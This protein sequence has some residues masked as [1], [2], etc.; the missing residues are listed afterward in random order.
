MIAEAETPAPKRGRPDGSGTIRTADNLQRLC[1]E[2]RKTGLSLQTCASLCGL[3]HRTVHKWMLEDVDA[4]QAWDQAEAEWERWTV[5]QI[6]SGEARHPAQLTWLLSAANRRRYDP[7]SLTPDAAATSLHVHVQVTPGQLQQI[8][9][10]RA[11]M[12]EDRSEA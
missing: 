1:D 12:L 7:K 2:V 9:E 5:Q 3:N 11:K 6:Q 10:T 4:R 8:Q